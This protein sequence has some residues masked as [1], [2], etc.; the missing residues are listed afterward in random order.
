MRDS[1][2]SGY[3]RAIGPPVIRSTLRGIIG[4]LGA[5]L[6]Q[7]FNWHNTCLTLRKRGV[8]IAIVKGSRGSA[9]FGWSRGGP[10]GPGLQGARTLG[11]CEGA[12]LLEPLARRDRSDASPPASPAKAPSRPGRAL[13]GPSPLPRRGALRAAPSRGRYVALRVVL[14]GRPLGCRYVCGGV[15]P[16]NPRLVGVVP[17]LQSAHS[18]PFRGHLRGLALTFLRLV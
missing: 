14:R 4:E 18:P 5:R 2:V 15:P 11:G 7:E 10:R 17:I 3:R 9:A 6:W 16:C 1:A 8:G 12:G 13:P